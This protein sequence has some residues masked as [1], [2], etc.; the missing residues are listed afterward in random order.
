M[1]TFLFA[2]MIALS[3]LDNDIVFHGHHSVNI[4]HIVSQAVVDHQT[5]VINWLPLDPTSCWVANNLFFGFDIYVASQLCYYVPMVFPKIVK[6]LVR[7]SNFTRFNV[8]EKNISVYDL[9]AKMY[10]LWQKVVHC[11]P[12]IMER[13]LF[14]MPYLSLS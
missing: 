7:S 12:L 5:W 9:L 11:T 13:M 14:H 4:I 3:D 6:I 10:W 2:Q 1:V 8:E